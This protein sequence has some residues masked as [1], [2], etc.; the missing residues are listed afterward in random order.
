MNRHPIALF[1]ALIMFSMDAN[2]EWV[3]AEADYHF[4]PDKSETEACQKAERKAKE[5]AL[6]SVTGEKIS[7]EDNMVCSE[8]KDD[9][10]CTLNRS[11][12]S[13]IDGLIKG[14]RNKKTKTVP[15]VSGYNKCRVSLEVNVGVAEGS[16]DPSFDIQVKLNRSTFRHGEALKIDL[17]PTQPMHI[18]VF[19]YLPY[20]DV[21]KQVTRVFPNAYDKKQLF[22]KAGSVP[23]YEGRK[24]YDMLVGFPEGLSKRK[25]LVDEYLM[26]LG[27]KKS[28]KFRGEYSL[29]EFNTRLLEIPRHDRRVVRRAYNVVRTK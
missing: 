15:A 3:S 16:P 28:I 24:Q 29:E 20:M 11:T 14:T 27:T 8:M 5:Q 23:T 10:E 7:S 17:L 2:A 1:S 26:V 13:T 12:W 9:A 21:E 19:Q 6:K 18:S 4:G 25:D 22:Q